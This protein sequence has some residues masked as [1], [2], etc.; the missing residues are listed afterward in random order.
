[1][2]K[3]KIKDKH[4]PYLQGKGKGKYFIIY[5]IHTM[6]AWISG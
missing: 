5:T 2:G 6:H 1:M 4:F 3:V